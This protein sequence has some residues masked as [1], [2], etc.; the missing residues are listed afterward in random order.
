MELLT[1]YSISQ[2][3]VT[4]LQAVNIFGVYESFPVWR[5]VRILP[6]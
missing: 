3:L 5:R 4:K 6:P 2:Q 1:I